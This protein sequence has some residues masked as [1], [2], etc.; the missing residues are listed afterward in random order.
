ML[1]AADHRLRIVEQIG[2]QHHHAALGQRVAELMERLRHVGFL[3]QGEPIERDE[4]G[5]EMAR[6]CAG[7]QQA[8]D[9][10]VERHEPNRVALAVHQVGERCRETGAVLELRHAA[11]A[12]G[13]RSADVEH[14]VAI[15]VG[16]L[17]E[18]LDVVAIAARVDLP[19]DC[20]EVVAGNVLA[21][22]RELDAEA[23]ERAAVEAGQ[24]AFDDRAGLELQRAEAR[25]DRRIQERPLAHHGDH[26][27]R[28]YIPLLGTATVSISR[29]ITVSEVMRSDSA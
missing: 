21:V 11:R 9:L 3:T 28:A 13:H 8:D 17:F 20:G 6:P 22:L 2:D 12:I 1:Q 15:E 10:V 27:S 16:F 29:S 4:G 25:D 5:T 23:F 14:H 24:E 19:V 26:V 18:F 7:R